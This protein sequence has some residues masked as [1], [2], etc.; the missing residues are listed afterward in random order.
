MA[1]THCT[2]HECHCSSPPMAT[3]MT[4]RG[5]VSEWLA[6]RGY[7]GLYSRRRGCECRMH[8][9]MHCRNYNPHACMATAY[10]EDA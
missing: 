5:I 6:A 4:V 10:P 3:G 8:S 9:L 1:I 2:C 7:N